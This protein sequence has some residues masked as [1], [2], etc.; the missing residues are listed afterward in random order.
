MK[1]EMYV[2]YER[3]DVNE[4]VPKAAFHRLNEEFE[5][6]REEAV[7]RE[8][9]LRIELREAL[10]KSAAREKELSNRIEMSEA[11]RHSRDVE[12][13]KIR[14]QY[15]QELAE[16]EAQFGHLQTEFL[17]EKSVYD[18]EVS[19]RKSEL[20][21]KQR[22]FEEELERI[23]EEGQK[24]LEENSSKFVGNILVN[25]E[26][27]EARLSRISFWSAVFGG[28]ILVLGLGYLIYLSF[29]SQ[30]GL[31]TDMSWPRLVFYAA[32]GAVI[33]GIIGVISRYAYVFSKEYLRESLRVD[34]K[35]HAIKFGQ[36]YVETYG[37]AAEW[38]QVK[39]AFSNWHGSTDGSEKEDSETPSVSKSFDGSDVKL[40]TEFLKSVKAIKG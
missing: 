18:I 16:R 26:E 19:K 21:E 30:M 1:N 3:G 40:A 35:I 34:D 31:S 20:D 12:I 2:D 27:K 25:L 36:L 8:E 7:N 6:Y 15:R 14:H 39:E 37:A 17:E 24:K 10:N 5:T 33:A 38:D 13:D 22:F 28:G 11:L 4:A 9:R 23:S 32:K 29:Q